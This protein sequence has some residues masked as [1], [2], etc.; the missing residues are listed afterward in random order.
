MIV[1]TN[2]LVYLV[3]KK[4]FNQLKVLTPDIREAI[5]TKSVIMELEG[6]TRSISGKNKFGLSLSLAKTLT[7][8][9]SKGEGDDAII[10]SARELGGCVLTND[11]ALKSRLRDCGIPVYSVSKGGRIISSR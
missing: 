11:K 9:N 5:V 1:D 3:E 4:A 7:L 2:A 10:S 8:Y 6:L